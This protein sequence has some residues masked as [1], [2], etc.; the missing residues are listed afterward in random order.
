[1]NET[2]SRQKNGKSVVLPCV[3]CSQP[4]NTDLFLAVACLTSD[5]RKYTGYLFPYLEEVIGSTPDG[6]VVK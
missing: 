5:S 3:P 4:A 1:M 2:T 6:P